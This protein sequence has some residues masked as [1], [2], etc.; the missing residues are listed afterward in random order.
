MDPSGQEVDKKS[1]TTYALF[2]ALLGPVWGPFGALLGRC[3]F[4]ARPKGIWGPSR[5]WGEKNVPLKMLRPF[6][7]LGV[8]GLDAGASAPSIS[9]FISGRIRLLRA[10]AR[11]DLEAYV[12]L[13][14]QSGDIA[15]HA[16]HAAPRRSPRSRPPLPHHPKKNRS[17]LRFSVDYA[18]KL[19][20]RRQRKHR[21]LDAQSAAVYRLLSHHASRTRP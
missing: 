12:E 3:A 6:D 7:G 11:V 2:G 8:H 13:A 15:D 17:A 1:P 16:A 4:G 9:A 18:L 20:A 5:F 10:V 19:G 14:L 21:P